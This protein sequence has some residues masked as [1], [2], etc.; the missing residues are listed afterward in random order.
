MSYQEKQAITTLASTL[1]IFGLYCLYVV[2]RVQSGMWDMADPL[3]F[4]A[5][6]FLVMIPWQVGLQVLIMIVFAIAVKVATNDDPPSRDDE[7]DTLIKLRSTA[8]SYYA[9]SGAFVVAMI[10]AVVGF[11]THVFFG[12]VLGAWIISSVVEQSARIFYYRRGI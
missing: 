3:R 11:G 8:Y 4:W 6:V 2:G 12:V 10:L 5:T 1:A 9:F 7:M